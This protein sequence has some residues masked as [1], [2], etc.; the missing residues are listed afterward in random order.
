MQ[1]KEK[2]FNYMLPKETKELQDKLEEFG[3]YTN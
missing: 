3:F 1:N 2:A